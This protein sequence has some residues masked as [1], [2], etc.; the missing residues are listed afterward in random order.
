[1]IKHYQLNPSVTSR[2]LLNK[3]GQQIE[4]R[5]LKIKA[6]RYDK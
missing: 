1:M 4:L 6:V 3:I 2:I 5:Q